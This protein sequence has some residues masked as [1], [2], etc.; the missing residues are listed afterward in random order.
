MVKHCAAA[1][2]LLAA[3]GPKDDGYGIP[4]IRANECPH[5]DW[6]DP[7]SPTGPTGGVMIVE[8]TVEKPVE[9]IVE[10]V[11]EKPVETIVERVVEGATGP[12]GPRGLTGERGPT[13]ATG[14]PG[15][16]GPEGAKG[17]KGDQG[18][19][20]AQG[21]QGVQGPKGDRGPQ[22]PAG[23]DSPLANFTF[24]KSVNPGTVSCDLFCVTA[25]W[26]RAG[27][28]IGARFV[29]GPRSGTYTA[30]AETPGAGNGLVCVCSNF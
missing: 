20:G 27:T 10:T 29:S 28:C 23:L 24:E 18:V 17:D 21:P 1:L 6:L 12:M 9:K 3:C 7:K 15:A 8:K 4:L 26:G 5:Y 19:Q 11:V 25:A 30:C 16:T 22:G 2:L 14:E 13:G